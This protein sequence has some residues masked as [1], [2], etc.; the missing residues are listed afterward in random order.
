M[1]AVIDKSNQ[2]GFTKEQMR[3]QVGLTKEQIEH[4]EVC[5]EFLCQESEPP[6]PIGFFVNLSFT[7]K[8]NYPKVY[9]LLKKIN[10]LN[11]SKRFSDF[12]NF[13]FIKIKKA[14]T[15]LIVSKA[16]IPSS[17]TCF[18]ENQNVVILGADAYPGKGMDAN[19]RMS[20]LACLAHELAHVERFQLGY[21]RPINLPDMLIDEAETSLHASFVSALSKRDRVD[22]LE[23]AKERINI[24]LTES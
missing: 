8:K 5:W 24:W 13:S 15:K 16:S 6:T 1:R 22:L 17:K 20:V 14:K 11:T 9:N 3:N 10:I 7:V 18:N 12:K 19:S 4:C 2:I 21:Q 23:D